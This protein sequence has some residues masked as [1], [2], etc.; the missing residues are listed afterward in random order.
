VLLKESAPSSE[1]EIL[2]RQ[3]VFERLNTGGIALSN[4]EIRNSIYQ[5][6]FSRLLDELSEMDL[7]RTAWK[8]PKHDP[9][10]GKRIPDQLARNRYFSTMR[11]TE[12]V[13]RFFAL[14][15]ASE[16]KAGMKNFLDR[17]MLR[18]K[19]FTEEDIS[20]LREV[21]VDALQL[22]AGLFGENLFRLWDAKNGNWSD[23]PQ[24]ALADAVMVACAKHVNDSSKLLNNRGE[25]IKKTQELLTMSPTGAFTGQRNT[26]AD[27]QARINAFDELLA[28]AGR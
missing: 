25:V 6:R 24:I 16:Y 21:F 8:I 7:F 12:I 28:E 15:Q 27:V 10:N 18:A 1:E 5:S 14:R 11:D 3:Q 26:K 22:A 9:A 20:F 2:L 17:Y 19:N 4:Q 13:L 23:T